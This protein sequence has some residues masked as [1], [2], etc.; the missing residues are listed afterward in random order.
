[1]NARVYE[2]S[3]LA[4]LFVVLLAIWVRAH[5]QHSIEDN[6]GTWGVWQTYGRF[7]GYLLAFFLLAFP[8]YT[9]RWAISAFTYTQRVEQVEKIKNGI[10]YFPGFKSEQVGSGP[11]IFDVPYWKQVSSM[12]K[13]SSRYAREAIMKHV[14]TDTMMIGGMPVVFSS[15][16]ED[17]LAKI[18]NMK[19]HPD[20]RLVE[21][22]LQLGRCYGI[23][24]AFQIDADSVIRRLKEGY[25][26][27]QWPWRQ[28]CLRMSELYHPWLPQEGRYMLI[29]AFAFAITVFMLKQL[30]AKKIMGVFFAIGAVVVAHVVVL[31]III[32]PAKMLF[33]QS[34]VAL[35]LLAI[36]PF[37]FLVFW[38]ASYDKRSEI[39]MLSCY[40]VIP[41][42]VIACLRVL[43]TELFFDTTPPLPELL[44]ESCFVFFA[45]GLPLISPTMLRMRMAPK[46][47]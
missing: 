21:G 7:W 16:L 2:L 28:A 44:M 11:L 12:T 4:F 46:E 33:N 35:C 25:D 1:M 24:E 8:L 39:F 34:G 9:F 10:Y 45:I 36:L 22:M 17:V 38:K 43:A 29:A 40:L 30:P 37:E 32:I 5:F 6:V 42:I 19:D 13:P 31:S 27:N 26:Y 3:A 15:S 18:D 20:M 47:M 14:S 41:I 23:K